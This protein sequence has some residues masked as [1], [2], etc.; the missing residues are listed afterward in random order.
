M[1]IT[2]ILNKAK[3]ILIKQPHTRVI[4]FEYEGKHYYIKRKGFSRNEILKGGAE[5]EFLREIFRILLVNQFVP[6]APKIIA[7][8][9]NFIITEDAGKSVF[10][11]YKQNQLDVYKL[12]PQI[13][14]ALALLHKNGLAHGRPYL[15]DMSWDPEKQQLTLL[16]WENKPF[17]QKYLEPRAVDLLLLLH[18]FFRENDVH[19]DHINLIID[20]YLK[21]PTVHTI[22]T[23]AKSIVQRYSI[24]YDLATLLSPFQMTD[25]EAYRK[26]VDYIKTKKNP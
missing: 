12:F 10:E 2:D 26:V 6:L 4:P 20:S 17:L 8:D 13:G 1:I 14:M 18:S 24:F 5:T 21:E 16:D 15:R 3:Q 22:Y 23:E 9:E 25:I 11:L 19:I 7:Y